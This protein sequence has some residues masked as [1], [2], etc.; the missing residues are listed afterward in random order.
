[1]ELSVRLPCTAVAVAKRS[2]QAQHLVCMHGAQRHIQQLPAHSFPGAHAQPSAKPTIWLPR[3]ERSTTTYC[4][5]LTSF[6]RK[7]AHT[8]SLIRSSASYGRGKWAERA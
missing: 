5:G 7:A 1:M 3:T 6:C 4:S 2:M 8:A